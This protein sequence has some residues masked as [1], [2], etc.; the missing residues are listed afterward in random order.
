MRIYY[1]QFVL[2]RASVL[3]LVLI[4]WGC[5]N[6]VEVDPPRNEL[7][8]SSVFDSN[9]TASAALTDIYYQLN[10]TGFASGSVSSIS[11][12]TTLLSDEQVVGTAPLVFS[13]FAANE[14][15]PDNSNVAELWNGMYKAIYQAN[16]IIEGVQN[17]TQITEEVAVQ[18]V[19]E[20]KFL[21]AFSHFYLLNLFGGVPIVTGTDYQLNTNIS[22]SSE[23]EVYEHIL[24]DLLECEAVLTDDYNFAGGARVRVNRNVVRAFLSRVYLYQGNWEKAEQFATTVID[25]SAYSLV[26]LSEIVS[27]NNEEAIWQ[28]YNNFYPNDL[29]AF[30]LFSAPPRLSSLRE[31]FVELFEGDDQR[32]QIWIGSVS[33]D[34]VTFFF[35]MKY[36]S[37][38]SAAQYSTVFRLAEQYLIR[39]EAKAQLNNVDGALADV[40]VIR[41][42]AGLTSIASSGEVEIMKVIEQERRSELFSEWGHRWFDLKRT[43]RATAV[44]S[45]LK[46]QWSETDLLLP[47]PEIQI[48]NDPSMKGSQNP[49]Y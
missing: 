35:P 20:A 48:K 2:S 1:A 33:S 15:R 3:A 42:R 25:N 39:A 7:V 27:Q 41:E 9:S 13:E 21:R 44:L 30:Y 38:E 16:A 17:S 49:G 26:A 34:A 43:G 47:I 8:R 40:N 23:S 4:A 5:E 29:L 36:H 45:S 24:K 12:L 32:R 37:L 18:I 28:L 46:P 10:R 11:Y 31:S 14:I 6:F 22:R 19:G